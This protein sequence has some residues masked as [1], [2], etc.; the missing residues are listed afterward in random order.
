MINWHQTVLQKEWMKAMTPKTKRTLI[1]TGIILALLF[2]YSVFFRSFLDPDVYLQLAY[3]H[4]GYDPTIID[5]RFPDYELVRYQGRWAIR[6]VFA[7]TE[8]A[9]RGPIGLYLDPLRKEVLALE[10]RADGA[11][12]NQFKQ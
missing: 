1:I 5:W 12:G 10:P 2:G 4:T 7:T 6:I 3:A 11:S 8:D 9:S